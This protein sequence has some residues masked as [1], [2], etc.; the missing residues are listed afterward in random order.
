TLLLA[1]SIRIGKSVFYYF[2]PDLSLI[3]LQFGLSACAFIGPSLYF[4]LRAKLTSGSYKTWKIHFGLIVVTLMIIGYLYPWHKHPDLWHYFYNAIYLEWLIY[5]LASLLLLKNSVAKIFQRNSTLESLEIWGLSLLA[6][7]LVIWIVYE[8]VDY[9]SYIGGALSFSFVFYLLI[10]WLLLNRKKTST[11]FLSKSKYG[12]KKIDEEEAAALIEKL[13]L[14]M[15]SEKIFRNT[16]LKLVEVAKRLKVHTHLLSQLI[17]DNLGSTFSQFVNDY[18]IEEAKLLI[19]SNPNIKLE[20][21]GYDCGFNSKSTF[22]AAFKKLEGSTPAQY[23]ENLL[24]RAVS[25][26]EL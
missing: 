14:I 19:K 11:I 12:D 25:G 18:R 5:I 1:L 23:K 21:I 15:H 7:N 3:F 6:G 10:L 22:Y 16:E 24:K 8:I 26:S 20:S 17:N 9:S 4:Y 13:K 2:N